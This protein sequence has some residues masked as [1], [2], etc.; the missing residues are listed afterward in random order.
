[1]SGRSVYRR[2]ALIRH[3]Q[4]EALDDLLRVTAPHER[5]FLLAFGAS[6]LFVLVAAAFL[7]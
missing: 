4:P 3:A 6:I 5:V 2:E 7:N 1:M